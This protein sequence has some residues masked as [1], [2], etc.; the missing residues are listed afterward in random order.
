[1]ALCW[2]VGLLLVYIASTAEQLDND[3]P[4]FLCIFGKRQLFQVQLKSAGLENVQ[5][6]Y[7]QKKGGTEQR[8][9]GEIKAQKIT[10]KSSPLKS[11]LEKEENFSF[12]GF[13]NDIVFFIDPTSKLP[14]QVNGEIP[15]AGNASL[16]LLEVQLK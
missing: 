4:L 2:K 15:K 13:Q 10:L 12:L 14:L 5:V 16:K 1:M 8:R 11:N 7:V 6:D 9:Q 3:K